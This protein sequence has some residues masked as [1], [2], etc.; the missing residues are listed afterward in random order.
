[1]AF[2]A[3]VSSRSALA[4][5]AIVD[6][7]SSSD[8]APAVRTSCPS[9]SLSARSKMAPARST[10]A[11]RRAAYDVSSASTPARMNSSRSVRA[12]FDARAVAA[13]VRDVASSHAARQDARLDRKRS[14]SASR[15]T[16]ASA[17]RAARAAVSS[18]FVDV[19][20]GAA[21]PTPP[22]VVISLN[23]V[24]AAADSRIG[25]AN[26]LS[27]VSNARTNLCSDR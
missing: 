15:A 2:F 21:V 26:P 22:S 9:S 19:D 24:R 4:R 13:F 12:M 20:V 14:S 27:P 25:S 3:D 7:K 6:A 16:S 11:G 23:P 1:M 8:S 18:S 5:R 10:S 17:L